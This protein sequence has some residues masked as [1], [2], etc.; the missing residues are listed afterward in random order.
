MSQLLACCCTAMWLIWIESVCA[1]PVLRKGARCGSIYAPAEHSQCTPKNALA[2]APT[3]ARFELSH[4][5]QQMPLSAFH[6]I[7]GDREQAI[8]LGVWRRIVMQHVGDD[9]LAIRC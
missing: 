1:T 4:N 3:F 2:T 6:N 7:T 8:V 9:D 5:L